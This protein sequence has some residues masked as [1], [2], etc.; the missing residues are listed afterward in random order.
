[1]GKG[2]GVSCLPGGARS[3]PG[4]PQPPPPLPS[5]ENTN[6]RTYSIQLSNQRP[7]RRARSD[8]ST[9]QVVN[10]GGGAR[11][12][13]LQD[14]VAGTAEKLQKVGRAAAD[15]HAGKGVGRASRRGGA[16]SSW[17]LLTVHS[18]SDAP[19]MGGQHLLLSC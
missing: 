3:H 17:V 10:E 12:Q 15:G 1:M 19:S 4:P 13:A 16:A 5:A 7:Q 6:I 8:R 18:G 11:M 2:G 9:Q 14:A